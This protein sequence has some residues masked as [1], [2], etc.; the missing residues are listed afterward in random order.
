MRSN[1][2]VG[3]EAAML[4]A[5]KKTKQRMITKEGEDCVSESRGVRSR[6]TGVLRDI[7]VV[8]LCERIVLDE[9]KRSSISFGRNLCGGLST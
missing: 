7:E 8:L 1:A 3:K 2:F 6:E 9:S 5:K 4:S